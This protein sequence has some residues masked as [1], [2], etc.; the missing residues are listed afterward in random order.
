MSLPVRI[1]RSSRRRK[2]LSASVV[3][4][5][6]EVR[7]PAGM[8]PDEERTHVQGLVDRVQRKY[9]APPPGNTPQRT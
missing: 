6:I 4:G 7:V 3:D 1:I 8:A 9:A 2:T 5:T